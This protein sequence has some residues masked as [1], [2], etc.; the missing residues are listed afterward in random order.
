MALAVGCSTLGTLN[1]KILAVADRVAKEVLDEANNNE[2]YGDN[3]PFKFSEYT[4]RVESPD[5][6]E[7]PETRYYVFYETD[8]ALSFL[9]HPQHFT[10]IVDPD[11]LKTEVIGG[12]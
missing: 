11:T 6:F 7:Q 2:R 8:R 1:R 3:R 5:K 4:R 12:E 10:V 9:G